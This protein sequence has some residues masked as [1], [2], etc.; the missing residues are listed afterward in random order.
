MV[1]MLGL[2]LAACSAKGKGT[3]GPNTEGTP[4]ETG[5]VFNYGKATFEF[6]LTCGIVN[7]DPVVAGDFKYRDRG[8]T[9]LDQQLLYG[10][11][12]FE[13][14]L[15]ITTV[16]ITDVE[17]G[18]RTTITTDAQGCDAYDAL[19][20]PA[21]GSIAQFL[22][23]YRVNKSKKNS[24]SRTAVVGSSTNDDD[25]DDDDDDDECDYR[26]RDN[27]DDDDDDCSNPGYAECPNTAREGCF[28]LL[29][30]DQKQD[31]Q[32]FLDLTGDAFTLQLFGGPYTGYTRAGYVERGDIKV[33]DTD[34]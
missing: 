30:F 9:F 12:H 17:T 7:G 2:V 26:A 21:P 24:D 4:V 33:R 14:G 29:V 19:N 3:L 10:P 23:V 20:N 18:T 8:S 16:V 27:D 34:R 13:G 11:V 5:T 25:D 22:G 28:N 6:D 1:V 32:P 31:T 15:I